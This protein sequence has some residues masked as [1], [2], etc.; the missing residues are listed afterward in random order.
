MVAWTTIYH[1]QDLDK[2]IM[3]SKFSDELNTN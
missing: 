2:K 3:L 1:E